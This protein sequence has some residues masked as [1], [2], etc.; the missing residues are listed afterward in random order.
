MKHI[1]IET[2]GYSINTTVFDDEKSACN[3][4]ERKYD[5]L[6]PHYDEAETEESMFELYRQS[7]ID[8]T[9]AS[10]YT[11]NDVYLWKIITV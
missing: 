4:M 6:D 3:E 9:Q 2:D 1:L 7:Y 10:L 11:G 5:D 8:T